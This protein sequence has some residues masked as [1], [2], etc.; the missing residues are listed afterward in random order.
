MKH[1]SMK[2]VG[3]LLTQAARLHRFHL[4]EQLADKGLY[5]GQEQLLRALVP[6]EALN[7]GDLSE[8]LQV[9]PPTV[10]KSLNRLAK[11]GL[12]ERYSESSDLR[13]VWVK[14]TSKGHAFAESI[15]VS[16]AKVE[17]DLMKGFDEKDAR[18]LGK[19]LRRASKNLTQALGGNERQFDVP[20][21]V[22]ERPAGPHIP[23]V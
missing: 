21:D 6:V 8:I 18:R 5:A 13:T 15:E 22:L 11:L 20:N 12:I 4:S 16:W 14:L 2:S 23:G 1:P 9:R 10:S 7:V 19:L 17:G 3:W